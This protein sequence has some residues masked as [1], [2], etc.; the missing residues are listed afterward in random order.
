MSRRL[1]CVC[2]LSVL[3]VHASGQALVEFDTE[4]GDAWT[5]EKTVSGRFA[6][7][8]CAS[9]AVETL[10]ARL[11]ALRV[12]DRFHVQVPLLPG[13]NELRAVC[14]GDDGS[15]FRSP[16][17]V[18]H[19]ALPD[20]PKAW[21][22]V[23]SDAS[24]IYLDAG[25]SERAP[26][27]IAPLERFEWRAHER[28]PAPLRTTDGQALTSDEPLAVDQLQ[29]AMPKRSGEYYV[30]L[31]VTDALRRSDVSTATFR[32]QAHDARTLASE[33]AHPLWV[34]SAVLYGAAPYMFEPQGLRGIEQRLDEIAALGATALWISP[35]TASAPD[36]FGYS[37]VDQ[38]SIR[39]D[40]GGAAA[41]RSL[42][43]TAHRLGLR[44]L[45]DFVPN[46]FSQFHAYYVDAEKNGKRSPYYDWFDRD[47]A[48]AVT[49]YFD[50]QHLKNLNF[51]NPEVRNHIIAAAARFIRQFEIDGF[52]IDAS[53]GVARRAPEFWP[54][55]REELQ[56][57]DPDLLLIAEASARETY[58]LANGFDAAYDWTENLGEWAWRDVFADDGT[59]DVQRLRNALT[60]DGRGYPPDSL[61]LRFINNND[62]GERFATR[63][64]FDLARLAATLIF[65][66]PGIPLIY[67]GDEIGAEF[68]P[69]DEG[70]PLSW[71]PTPLTNHYRKLTTLR[72]TVAALHG[73][74]LSL[75]ET[76]HDATTLAYLRAGAQ[77]APDVI[78][79]L[80]FGSASVALSASD[81]VSRAQFARADDAVDLLTNERIRM[82]GAKP[83]IVVPARS[84]RILR[85]EA[86][87]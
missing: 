71:T 51:D 52:R 36:D 75:L 38:F 1:A 22:R 15:E 76:N 64:G 47:A 37:V 5:F 60:N 41:L 85:L 70:P 21:I 63:Y 35:V 40:F 39:Q 61:I 49:Q 50:W 58:H 74:D 79:L 3:A 6:R 73:R 48:G 83:A 46:H 26:S 11:E 87:R 57:I 23:R 72:R 44:V 33:P 45:V 18:W 19:T 56:R 10:A 30:S 86:P 27:L 9:I 81:A 43:E 82:S 59:V 20:L 17:Q 67:N 42:V 29:L 8:R 69:Y 66:L 16:L 68:M 62:T 12:A 34:D 55:L 14:T 28:N 7:E 25:R 31:Q 78:V 77:G 65:T 54:Q 80:N 84:A 53:W 32:V 13:R 2:L 4:G 24:A